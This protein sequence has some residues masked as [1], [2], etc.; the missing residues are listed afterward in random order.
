MNR[1]TVEV[2]LISF[3]NEGTCLNPSNL[4][5]ILDVANDFPYVAEVESDF[6][7]TLVKSIEDKELLESEDT[8]ITYGMY[9]GDIESESAEYDN[10][11]DYDIVKKIDITE[12]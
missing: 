9:E 6:N 4:Q 1:K 8:L 10:I 12:Y 5:S 3:G 2:V 11:V 7:Y